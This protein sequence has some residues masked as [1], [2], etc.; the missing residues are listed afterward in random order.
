MPFGAQSFHLGI[1]NLPSARAAEWMATLA[2]YTAHPSP[3]ELT[4]ILA[5]LNAEP[6]V[7]VV[8][9]HPM[10]DLYLIGEEKHQ[11]L[12][13]EFLEKTALGCTPWS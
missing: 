3:A 8:F 4:E 9:N 11:F 7:L 2:D 1:H 13:G 12:V 6:N 10:W 5:A